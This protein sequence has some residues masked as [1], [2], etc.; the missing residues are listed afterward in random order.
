MSMHWSKLFRCP[1][2]AIIA[3]I[4]QDVR[5]VFSSSWFYIVTG[6]R[7]DDDV[8]SLKN[9][10]FGGLSSSFTRRLSLVFC[11]LVSFLPSFIVF[12]VN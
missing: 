4:L 1:T 7:L 9:I 6:S 2:N 11:R 5:N 12:R 3:G 8:D 10:F